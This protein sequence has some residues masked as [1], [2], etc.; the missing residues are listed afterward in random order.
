MSDIQLKI[1][2]T[3]FNIEIFGAVY[4]L[5]K[6]NWSEIE[7]YQQIAVENEGKSSLAVTRQLVVALGI[8]EDVACELELDHV[9]S[10]LELI[11]PKK[12]E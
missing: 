1:S 5:R 11:L 4:T 3:V 7:K 8:P 2:K 6:P 10:I 12:K 9:N